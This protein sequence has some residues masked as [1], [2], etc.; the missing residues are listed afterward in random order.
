VLWWL[1]ARVLTAASPADEAWEAVRLLE[2]DTTARRL[3]E[4]LPFPHDAPV[5]VYSW[6]PV[7]A[8]ALAD[9]PD[10]DV[11]AVPR[12]GGEARLRGR[13]ARGG[14]TVR[15]MSAD[16]LAGARPS[17]LLVEATAASPGRAIVPLGTGELLRT[18]PPGTT[19]VLVAGVGRLL[20]ERLLAVLLRRLDGGDPAGDGWEP[21]PVEQFE[22]VAGPNGLRDPDTLARRVDCPVAPELLRID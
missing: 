19:T 13:L 16:E 18:R 4:R 1:C 20:P 14:A 9:R 22:R 7:A 10:L 15:T 5:A 6:S 21:V 8:A 11:V 17:H 3:G 2:A 12:D